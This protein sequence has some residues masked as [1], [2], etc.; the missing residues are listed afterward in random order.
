MIK[1]MD[2]AAFSEKIAFGAISLISDEE[3][4]AVQRAFGE[5]SCV[6]KPT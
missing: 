4:A 6:L 2:S 1:I 3:A 5:I